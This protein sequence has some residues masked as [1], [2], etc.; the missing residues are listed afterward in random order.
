MG[1]LFDTINMV[2]FINV[3]NNAYYLEQVC[4]QKAG[5]FVNLEQDKDQM[6]GEYEQKLTQVEWLA[7]SPCT[8]EKDCTDKFYGN[9]GL[10]WTIVWPF[11]DLEPYSSN[12]EAYNK[13]IYSYTSY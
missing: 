13:R 11:K 6:V 5:W 3:F 2:E 10:H 1:K 8:K 9:F 4:E 12:H 7:P